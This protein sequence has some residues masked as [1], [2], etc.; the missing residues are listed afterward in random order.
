MIRQIV[1]IVA[2]IVVCVSC[3]KE[4]PAQID[5]ADYINNAYNEWV[6]SVDAKDIEWWSSF[7]A[8]NAVFLPPDG[9]PLETIDAIKSRY[10]GLFQDPNFGLECMQIFV[11]VAESRDIAWSRG[12]CNAA[13]STPDGNVGRASSKWTKVWVRLDNGSWKCRLNT[14]NDN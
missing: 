3:S 11:D 5:D 10:E 6:K 1:L 7:L 9:P 12:T 2:V 14:W 13:F 4:Q 8:P